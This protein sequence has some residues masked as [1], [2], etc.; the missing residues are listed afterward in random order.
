MPQKV[1]VKQDYHNTRFDRWFKS[2]VIDLLNTRFDR[3]FKSNVIDLPQSLIQKILRLNKI[4]INRKKVKTSYRVQS[5]DIVEIYDISKFKISN[6]PKIIKYKPSRK[7]VDLYDDYILEN[8]KN[9]IVINKPRVRDVQ[10][11]SKSFKNIIDVL[12]D[13]KY[14]EK[15]KPF[16]VHRLDKDT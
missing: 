15:T 8:N 14:F 9:F 16:I 10:A 13:S 7:E 3:W 1:T 2:N 6:R 5:G 11:G 12:K 4:K